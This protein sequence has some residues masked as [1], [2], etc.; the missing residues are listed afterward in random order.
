MKHPIMNLNFDKAVKYHADQFPPKTLDYAKFVAELVKATDAIARYDQMLKNMHNNEIRL[1]PL[2]NQ[3]AVISSRIEGT[4]STMDEILQFEADDE[5]DNSQLLNYRSDVVETILYQRALKNAQ[6]GIKDGYE[7]STSFIK[8]MHQQL[9]YF[10]RGAQKS[11]GQFKQEQNFLADK[12]K[13]NI[14]FIPIS[15]EKLIDGID[16]LFQYLKSSEHPVLVKTALMHLEFEALHPFQDGNGRIGRMLITLYLW[17]TGVISEPHFYISGYLEENKDL[18]IDTMRNVSEKGDWESWCVFFLK[19]VEQQAIQNLQISENIRNLYEEMKGVFADILS[20]KW[21]VNTL[22]YIFTNPLFRNSKFTSS[23]GIP[24]PTAA[25][26]TRKLLESGL[27]ITKQEA[28]G[29]RS[30]LYSF[31]PLMRLVRV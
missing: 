28:S 2:R 7:I 22:D 4:V 30:A 23:S 14:L 12:L 27:I 13:K 18:Y 17:S 29:R 5:G 10:G 8:Q 1:A 26:F 9:L 6:K 3:E 11:P 16:N 15:P 21:S 25:K 31:E 24:G 20:S 19:A